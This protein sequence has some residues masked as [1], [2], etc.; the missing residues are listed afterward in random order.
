MDPTFDDESHPR[1][2][3]QA[4]GDRMAAV[5]SHVT[6]FRLR[7]RD[8]SGVGTWIV[9]VAVPAG[10]PYDADA[11]HRAAQAL[12]MR[13]EGFF[14]YTGNLKTAIWEENLG[15]PPMKGGLPLTNEDRRCAFCGSHAPTWVHP[16]D[17]TKTAFQ[18]TSGPATLPNFWT[19][20]QRCEDLV[21]TGA[22]EK[23]A[24]LLM[25]GQADSRRDA[26]QVVDV[27][28]D[29]DTGPRPIVHIPI[30]D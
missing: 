15:E 22:D 13:V 28:R 26:V 9:S 5:D 23:L 11:L 7:N 16:F 18:W 20:C 19:V 17:A 2:I 14:E 27:F 24:T 1:D 4:I 10:H 30:P 6:P 29:A 25:E 21:R 8:R 12:G 3:E